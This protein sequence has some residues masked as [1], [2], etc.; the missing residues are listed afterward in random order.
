MTRKDYMNGYGK[1]GAKTHREYYA[2]FVDEVIKNQ[3]LQYIGKG[4]LLASIDE[5]LN[6]IPL[7][8]WD[9]LAGFKFIGSEMVQQPRYI[10]PELLKKLRDT[11]EGVSCA[12]MVCIYKEAARQIIEAEVKNAL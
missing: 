6:D 11:G 9:A 12:G 4:A 3:V 2:Q 5:H 10:R 1:N 8:K 7:H